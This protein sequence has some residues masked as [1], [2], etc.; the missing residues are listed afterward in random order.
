MNNAVA[1]HNMAKSADPVRN[2]TIL[3]LVVS[4]KVRVREC[5][6]LLYLLRGKILM[7]IQVMNLRLLKFKV[8]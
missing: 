4:M 7:K 6:K 5:M 8:Y 3:K 2:L 1:Q